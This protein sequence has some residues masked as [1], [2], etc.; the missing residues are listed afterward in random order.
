MGEENDDEDHDI[1]SDGDSSSSSESE[2]DDADCNDDAAKGAYTKGAGVL[3]VLAARS[4]DAKKLSDAAKKEGADTVS[5]SRVRRGLTE[6]IQGGGCMGTK[7]QQ[8]R[9]TVCSLRF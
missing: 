5:P 8:T 6:G 3:D 1:G 2:D 7:V 4:D 9:V